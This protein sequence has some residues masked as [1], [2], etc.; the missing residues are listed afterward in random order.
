MGIII[1]A[2]YVTV[3]YQ[4]VPTFTNKI[5][6]IDVGKYI[7]QL[8]P[9]EP[10]KKQNNS[11]FPLNPGLVNRDPYVMVYEISPIKLGSITLTPYIH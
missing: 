7:S 1:P 3:V 9:N 11:Y 4:R 5:N 8:N 6:N 2:S 10:R